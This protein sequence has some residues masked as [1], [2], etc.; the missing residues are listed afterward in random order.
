MSAPEISVV[1]T[2]YREGALITE[3]IDSILTQTFQ[4]FEIILVDNNADPETVRFAQEAVHKDPD[5]VRIVKQPIQ[6]LAS[7]RNK[8]I[9]ECRGEYVVFHDGD[10]L[11]HPDRLALQRLALKN[12]P[13]LSF[14][15]SWYDLISFDKKIIQKD[16]SGTFP[17]FWRENEKI[18]NQLFQD[19]SS[20]KKRGSLMF[21]LSPTCFFRR[22]TVLAT[23]WYDERLNPRWYEENEFLLR[24]FEQ[25]DI[26]K[27][28]VSLLS[29]RQHSTEGAIII[30][31]Q[32]DWVNKLRHLNIFF[33][34]VKEKHG[35][36]PWANEVIGKLRAYW[37][38]YVSV[39]F[40][41]YDTG[42]RLGRIALER[43]FKANPSD[44]TT[45][46]LMAKT[47]L[48]KRDYPKL[49]WF[50]SLITGPLPEGADED[51]VRSLFI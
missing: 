48:P 12:R 47:F 1:I 17:D 45:L 40:L 44:R 13:D 14:V 34:I 18:L 29:Y 8:G 35:R 33:N 25:G 32:M 10:D 46:K 9:S 5:R 23:G 28:P 30:K 24:V 36:S 50:D 39:F 49:F 22:E 11:S 19:P 27:I 3:T 4:D 38:R 42:T 15:G 16:V 7:A 51:F 37:L 26:W 41:Q 20:G 6:G 2:M 21:P 43:S 31:N